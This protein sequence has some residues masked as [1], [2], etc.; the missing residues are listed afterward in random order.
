MFAGSY[1][2]TG[3]N[4]NGV[5]CESNPIPVDSPNG[6]IFEGL[7]V[8][9][10]NTIWVWGGADDN[11]SP[12]GCDNYKRIWIST[13]NLATIDHLWGPEVNTNDRSIVKSGPTIRTNTSRVIFSYSRAGI[14]INRQI[15]VADPPTY[16]ADPNGNLGAANFIYGLETGNNGRIFVYGYN[17]LTEQFYVDDDFATPFNGNSFT[18]PYA[19]RYEYNNA[20]AQGISA[21]TL[22]RQKVAA[23][24]Q[25]GY[26]QLSLDNGINW[27]SVGLPSGTFTRVGPNSVAPS[28]LLLTG[29]IMGAFERGVADYVV[30]YTPDD[31]FSCQDKSGILYN[32]YGIITVKKIVK[33]A[34]GTVTYEAPP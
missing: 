8:D 7:M 29:W 31:G 20:L 4:T 27:T 18:T 22:N 28:N 14:G 26:L 24:G 9:D 6:S 16:T 25:P 11:D 17:D 10:E 21:H 1:A 34:L 30:L 19:L 33:V 5:K 2:V 23:C 15:T 12:Q 32:T 13:D 3:L